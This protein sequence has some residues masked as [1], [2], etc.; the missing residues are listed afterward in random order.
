MIPYELLQDLNRLACKSKNEK[1]EALFVKLAA[2]TQEGFYDWIIKNINNKLVT[3]DV[4]NKWVLTAI[5]YLVSNPNL[6]QDDLIELIKSPRSSIVNILSALFTLKDDSRFKAIL[7]RFSGPLSHASIFATKDP[8]ERAQLASQVAKDLENLYWAYDNSVNNPN[9]G[10]GKK[11]SPENR[12]R[13]F[14]FLKTEFSKEI[15]GALRSMP[16]QDA[17]KYKNVLSIVES[18]GLPLFQQIATALPY[19]PNL[20]GKGKDIM[21]LVNYAARHD[22]FNPESIDVLNTIKSKVF[23]IAEL[24]A[25]Q[26]VKPQPSQPSQPSNDGSQ[27]SGS[28]QA[29]AVEYETLYTGQA[30]YVLIISTMLAKLSQMWNLS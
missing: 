6:N 22:G 20:G 16:A 29:T 18:G 3:K 7:N 8:E 30:E 11:S 1:I 15:K 5:Q 4:S 12:E 13:R 27:N 14:N 26:V 25:S 24:N 17:P 23:N 19:M 10:E 28:D 2:Q 9:V 21:S